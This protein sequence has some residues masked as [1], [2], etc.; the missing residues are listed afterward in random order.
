MTAE[1]G[2]ALCRVTVVAPRMRL[3]VAVPSDVPLA[4]LVPTLLW[5]A[6]EH[7]AE[8]GAGHGGW[9]LQRLGGHPFDTSRSLA[10][11]GVRD[12]EI[13]YFRPRSA[14]LPELHFDDP[15]DG[16]AT[17]LREQTARWSPASTRRC[18]LAGVALLPATGIAPLIA[19]GPAWGLPTLIAGVLA[20]VLV[21]AAGGMSRAAGDGVAGVCLGL[22]AVP[23]AAL[24]GFLAALGPHPLSAAGAAS[25]AGAGAAAFTASVLAMA[26]TGLGTP[27]PADR[28]GPAPALGAGGHQ[29]PDRPDRPDG[30]P[31]GAALLAAVIPSAV[32]AV[33]GLGALH[34]SAEGCAALGAAL[35]LALS[36]LIPRIAYRVAGLPPAAVSLNADDLRR[37]SVPLPSG[38]LAIRALAADRIITGSV[39][40][41]SMGVLL[42]AAFALHAPGGAPVVLGA[43]FAML[44]ALRAR[45][46]AGVAQRWW[47]IGPALVLAG[48]CAA[49]VPQRWPGGTGL[50]ID[51][52]AAGTATAAAGQLALRPQRRYAPPL[53]RTADL[54]EL[55]GLIATIPLALLI[56][57]VFGYVRSLA[58]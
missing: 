48:L 11:S 24:T 2:A 51:L 39:A 40:G 38:T 47:L 46:L 15:V 28:V 52:L 34:W 9:A 36:V 54:F 20:L 50:A 13:L 44:L 32:V 6:G 58:G 16:V 8:V 19:H 43:T 10:A 26:F 22:A 35:V 37:L 18:A 27:P 42:C 1:I 30:P 53:S 25:V 29:D 55:V 57:G 23:Y 17:V 14:V 31:A 49:I 7:T 5:H 4:Q 56:L 33:G 41:V 21:L 45:I 12:G 3:D